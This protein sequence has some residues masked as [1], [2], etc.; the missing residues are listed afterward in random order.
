MFCYVYYF[1]CLRGNPRRRSAESACHCNGD[2]FFAMYLLGGKCR[3]RT[4]SKLS[5]YF[6]RLAMTRAGASSITGFHSERLVCISAMYGNTSVQL[7]PWPVVLFAAAC[8]VSKDMNQLQTWM[9][10]P[11]EKSRQQHKAVG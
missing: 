7:H 1:E 2:L 6:A 3:S 8:R 5:D 9:A 11:E 4:D 10:Q